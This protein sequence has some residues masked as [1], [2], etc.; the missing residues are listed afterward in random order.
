MPSNSIPSLDAQLSRGPSAIHSALRKID[1]T[2]RDGRSRWDRPSSRPMKSRRQYSAIEK[3]LVECRRQRF[4]REVERYFPRPPTSSRTSGS[5]DR[6]TASQVVTHL[7]VPLAPSIAHL[8][9]AS[10][11]SL[12]G[13]GVGSDE[14]SAEEASS[15][16][17]PPIDLQHAVPDLLRNVWPIH[18]R[19][20]THTSHKVMPLL[21]RLANAGL[22]DVDP[23]VDREDSSPAAR[24]IDIIF[25]PPSTTPSSAGQLE[26]EA[27]RFTFPHLSAAE[28]RRILGVESMSRAERHRRGQWWHIHEERLL[29]PVVNEEVRD[30]DALVG[31]PIESPYNGRTA[32]DDDDV[33]TFATESILD[34]SVS[35][36]SD[37][38]ADTD[39]DGR[40][41]ESLSS[42]LLVGSQVAAWRMPRLDDAGRVVSTSATENDDDDDG[43][44][45]EF[46]YE[47][48]YEY[49]V[50]AVEPGMEEAD[51]W[52]EQQS[53][54]AAGRAEPRNPA[55]GSRPSGGHV[56][57]GGGSST[58]NRTS[59][60]YG[61]DLDNDE[62]EETS[63]MEVS[64]VDSSLLLRSR[65]AAAGDSTTTN[66]SSPLS[67]LAMSS[68]ISSGAS[69]WAA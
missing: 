39:M 64:L 56:G 13:G 66:V 45:C 31:T 55:Q 22:L 14:L 63:E 28:L 60:F 26:P 4:K 9:S 8:L 59:T 29:L 46:E 2:K 38:H 3:H 67:P 41:E 16:S 48:E 52:A 34:G 24:R 20:D 1:V 53:S 33:S 15:S 19:F 12:G 54:A 57:G 62:E 65:N 47:Y 51:V 17:S 43:Q 68:S 42:S 37:S 6:A 18:Q 10:S 5:H 25:G 27:L 21:N 7:L 36:D 40:Y 32:E 49:E 58:S 11:T 44:D 61:S 23:D 35:V 50:M 69:V 30:G